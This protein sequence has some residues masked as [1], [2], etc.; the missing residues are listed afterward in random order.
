MTYQGIIAPAAGALFRVSA[1]GAGNPACSRSSDV[2]ELFLAAEP[3]AFGDQ[4]EHHDPH[5]HQVHR[6]CGA[7]LDPG[8]PACGSMAFALSISDRKNLNLMRISLSVLSI[9]LPRGVDS[10]REQ[11]KNKLQS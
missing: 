10:H 11:T 9:G 3:V 2:E 8:S 6:G 5:G 4:A 7:V 1:D